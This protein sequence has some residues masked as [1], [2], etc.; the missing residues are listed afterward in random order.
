M[1]EAVLALLFI[2]ILGSIVWMQRT[3]VEGWP[4]GDNV[5]KA[6][7][8]V[9][10]KNTSYGNLNYCGQADGCG[11]KYKARIGGRNANNGNNKFQLVKTDGSSTPLVSGDIVH[12]KQKDVYL[13]HCTNQIDNVYGH[14]SANRDGSSGSWILEKKNKDNRPIEYG[15]LIFISLNRSTHTLKA[16]GNSSSCNG[17]NAYAGT[18]PSGGPKQ[19]WRIMRPADWQETKNTDIKLSTMNTNDKVS[20]EVTTNSKTCTS[21]IAEND[22]PYKENVG[23]EDFVNVGY[24][25]E[26]CGAGNDKGTT[27]SSRCDPFCP[28]G[29]HCASLMKDYCLSGSNT[30]NDTGKLNGTDA[31][32]GRFFEQSCVTFMR[33][34]PQIQSKVIGKI[35]A[36]GDNWKSSA[37]KTFCNDANNKEACTMIMKNK[38]SKPEQW[39]VPECTA[40]CNA[41]CETGN[42]TNRAE[43]VPFVESPENCGTAQS[44]GEKADTDACACYKK[45]SK[46]GIPEYENAG[47][48]LDA[49]TSCINT[50]CKGYMD[51][52]CS[53]N[54]VNCV[55]NF[56]QSHGVSENNEQNLNCNGD[57]EMMK[58]ARELAEANAESHGN[59]VEIDISPVEDDDIT[60]DEDEELAV[61]DDDSDDEV[62]ASNKNKTENQ[63][64]TDTTDAADT[65]DTTDAADTTNAKAQTQVATQSSDDVTQFIEKNKTLLI[66][67]F[68]MFVLL[69]LILKL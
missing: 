3:V 44:P 35:C 33:E 55:Q 19:T 31:G 64:T 51:R 66:T 67:G 2:L 23:G 6:N 62:D 47:P 40:W 28:E 27:N 48:A 42:C 8:S 53:G 29:K 30:F 41:G 52:A 69:L 38:C 5:V 60:D 13:D 21:G 7:D 56:A 15:D 37:C 43:C 26:C 12:I 17:Y 46:S 45:L 34:N 57:S 49:M 20:L 63:E 58:E 1:L 10:L 22:S 9:R 59:G 25:V 32:E 68:A 54:I 36:K 18:A 65:T 4:A 11:A 16:A 14:T 61:D 50:A 39:G 24:K